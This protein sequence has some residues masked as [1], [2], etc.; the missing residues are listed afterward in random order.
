MKEEDYL[1]AKEN[2]RRLEKTTQHLRE[3]KATFQMARVLPEATFNVV[4]SNTINPRATT[5]T[6]ESLTNALYSYITSRENLIVEIEEEF[7]NL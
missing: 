3:A 2:R 7:R 6:S 5:I 4:E 1:K